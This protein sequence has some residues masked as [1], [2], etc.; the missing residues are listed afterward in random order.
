MNWDRMEGNWTGIKGNVLEQW[1]DLTEDRLVSRIQETDGISD[2]ET[3]PELTDW[4]RRLS[5]I[6]RV[7]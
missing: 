7:Q 2:D 1:D 6:E 4:Q 5:E 3:E